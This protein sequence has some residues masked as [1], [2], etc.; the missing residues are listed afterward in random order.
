MDQARLNWSEF[1]GGAKTSLPI[2]NKQSL[3]NLQKPAAPKTDQSGVKAK[4]VDLKQSNQL[5]QS[6]S[7]LTQDRVFVKRN[8]PLSFTGE[9]MK[10]NNNIESVG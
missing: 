3:S 4:A 5:K 2:P 9:A 10:T 8:N 6:D 1:T 7:T